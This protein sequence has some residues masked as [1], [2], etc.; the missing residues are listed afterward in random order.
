[1][2][3]KPYF[4]ILKVLLSPKLWAFLCFFVSLCLYH[5]IIVF[6]M[7]IVSLHT[8]APLVHSFVFLCEPECTGNRYGDNCATPCQCNITNSLECHHVT[9]NCTCQNGWEGNTCDEDTDECLFNCTG[10]HENCTNF[11]GGYQCTCNDGY[12]YNTSMICVG[13]LYFWSPLSLDTL[14]PSFSTFSVHTCLH[15]CVCVWMFRAE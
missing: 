5:S 7:Y 14:L 1:M 3:S 11:N 9:G 6:Y 13:T 2:I 8:L 10:Q 12:Q 15:V 4:R